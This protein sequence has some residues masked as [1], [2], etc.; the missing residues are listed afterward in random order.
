M[1]AQ[2]ETLIELWLNHYLTTFIDVTAF[3]LVNN[4]QI[5][6]RETFREILRQA[7]SS[8]NYSLA[9]SVDVPKFKV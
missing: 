6:T 7:W 8:G 3:E 2:I 1:A 4:W 5:Y 9:V